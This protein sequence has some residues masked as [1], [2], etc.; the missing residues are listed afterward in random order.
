MG[1]L[2]ERSGRLCAFRVVHR[3]GWKQLALGARRSKWQQAA[4]RFEHTPQAEEAEA[5]RRRDWEQMKR[6]A[7]RDRQVGLLS[8]G[9][10]F[11]LMQ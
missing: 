4:V 1:C 11:L 3:A 10:R 5:A 9:L 7:A 2:Q 6:V 8:F